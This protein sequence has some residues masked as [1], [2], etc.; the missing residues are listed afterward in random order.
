M[1]SDI[2]DFLLYLSSNTPLKQPER[3]GQG[4]KSSVFL[5]FFS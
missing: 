3:M 1:L 4:A 5:I 2:L